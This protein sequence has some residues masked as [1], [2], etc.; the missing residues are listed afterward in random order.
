MVFHITLFNQFDQIDLPGDRFRTC[1]GLL[2]DNERQHAGYS[3]RHLIKA[4]IT[5]DHDEHSLKK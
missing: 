1:R 4:E 2:G 3:E 5:T